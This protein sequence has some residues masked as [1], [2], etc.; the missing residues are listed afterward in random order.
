MSMGHEWSNT[1]WE[2]W[3]SSHTLIAGLLRAFEMQ[4]ALQEGPQRP[5]VGL[6]TPHAVS[7]RRPT[8]VHTT[9]IPRMHQAP[10][11]CLTLPAPRGPA[12]IYHLQPSLTVQGHGA[13][14]VGNTFMIPDTESYEDG[15]SFV[16]FLV[17][18]SFK[19][20][21]FTF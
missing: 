8:S 14:P 12:P 9:A 16:H 20:I 6:E 15:L 19:L 4:M 11:Q 10:F 3:G 2:T 13:V 7:V 17:T 21:D 18:T 5:S 1:L